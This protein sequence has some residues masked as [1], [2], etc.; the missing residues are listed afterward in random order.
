MTTRRRGTFI[1]DISVQDIRVVFEIRGKLEGLC[2]RFMREAKRPEAERVLRAALRKLEAAVKAN[3]KQQLFFADMELHCAIWRLSEQPHLYR[4]LNTAVGPFIFQIAQ[5]YGVKFPAKST[6]EDHRRYVNMILTTPVD[7]VERAVERYFE[8]LLGEL[9]L[10]VDTGI[11]RSD[12]E[13]WPSLQQM[14]A[15]PFKGLVV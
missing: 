4:T 12:S 14:W 11:S 5:I 6:L 15:S 2:V 10:P 3:D 13:P 9:P 8:R 1:R 7:R